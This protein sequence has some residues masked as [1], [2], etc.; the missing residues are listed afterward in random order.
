MIINQK[1]SLWMGIKS[2][3][4][5]PIEQLVPALKDIIDEFVSLPLIHKWTS[6][7]VILYLA[8]PPLMYNDDPVTFHII[9]LNTMYITISLLTLTVLF[10][11]RHF[12]YLSLNWNLFKRER[13]L[14]LIAFFFML[15]SLAINFPQMNMFVRAEV[16]STPVFYGAGPNFISIFYYWLAFLVFFVGP[17]IYPHL[18]KKLIT[19][20]ILLSLFITG[21]LI[22]YQILV[23]DF[24]GVARTYL[25]GFGNSN[26][27]P[28]AFA[29]FG[30]YLLIPL[31][32]QKKINVY[33]TTLGI[34]FFVVVLLSIS[35]AAWVALAIA[36]LGA[37][38]YLIISKH[39]EWK[40]LGIL[41]GLGLGVI[42][43]LVVVLVGLGESVILD[44]FASLLEVFSSDS[45]LAAISSLR[46]PLWASAIE[47]WLYGVADG[48]EVFGLNFVTII[49]GNG[50]SVYL[51]VD[52]GTQYLVT[53]VHQMFFDVLMS[54]G[55]VVFALFIYFLYLQFKYVFVLLSQD[56]K[57]L[58]LFSALLFIMGKWLFNSLNGLHAPF[59]YTVPV[60][61]FAYYSLSQDLKKLK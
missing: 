17:V 60:L 33:S 27:T 44:D 52:A 8:I 24:M 49:F 30:I 11:Y 55:I 50:Q 38:I 54:A 26:Y 40:R 34:F 46:T 48:T 58:S 21:A 39:V 22:S 18:P 14:V 25:F 23:D 31:L 28:D 13:W 12:P 51:W 19:S 3:I 32:Y 5:E 35:R 6:L 47:M 10:G 57:Y 45:D 41:T 37:I 43:L 7:L 9:K 16:V 56:I 1:N 61:I 4:T 53:N 15:F 36:V 59:V 42:G 20:L 2:A 29:I